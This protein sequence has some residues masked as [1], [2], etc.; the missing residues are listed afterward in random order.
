[1]VATTKPFVDLDALDAHIR[2]LARAELRAER[3]E[4]GSDWIDQSRSPLGRRTHCSLVRSGE[5]P[6]VRVHRRVLVRRRDLDAYIERHRTVS[7]PIDAPRDS[8]AR[9]L[10][11]VGAV[12][13]AR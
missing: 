7:A 4:P 3:D 11:R 9:T 12:R 1:M 13:V 6:G 8:E 2:S 10:A 5:L